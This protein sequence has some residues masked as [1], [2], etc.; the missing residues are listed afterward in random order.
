[1]GGK[2]ELKM[3]SYDTIHFMGSYRAINKMYQMPFEQEKKWTKQTVT[4]DNS[5]CN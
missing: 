1:M 3:E 5:I 4:M 2:D